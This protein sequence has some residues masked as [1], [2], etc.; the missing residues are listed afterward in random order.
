M[1]KSDY[2]LLR[3]I[4]LNPPS[5]YLLPGGVLWKLLKHLHGV[6]DYEA[7][8]Y[9][10]SKKLMNDLELTT[11]PTDK[12]LFK[13][14]ITSCSSVLE[15]LFDDIIGSGDEKFSRLNFEAGMQF[16][17]ES[18]VFLTFESLG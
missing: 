3:E 9:K 4:H 17:M 5:N 11:I 10:T 14:S 12:A 15:L 1:V 8:C 7:Y 2:S 6:C 13:P 18:K 16:D